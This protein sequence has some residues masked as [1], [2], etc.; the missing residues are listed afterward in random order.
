MLFIIITESILIKL[1]NINFHSIHILSKLN[2]TVMYNIV[3]TVIHMQL[4]LATYIQQDY[5][6]EVSI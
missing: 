1:I 4:L 3:C 5:I 6:G 2:S